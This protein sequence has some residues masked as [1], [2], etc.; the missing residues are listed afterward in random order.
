MQVNDLPKAVIV[1]NPADPAQSPR[2]GPTVI[3][4]PC[5]VAEALG[6]R[7]TRTAGIIGPL[8]NVPPRVP[9]PPATSI[10]S[11]LLAMGNLSSSL[12]TV[13]SGLAIGVEQYQARYMSHRE[14]ASVV[15]LTA[16]ALFT[17]S[18]S[19]LAGAAVLTIPLRNAVNPEV[20][21]TAVPTFHVSL[22]LEESRPELAS[23]PAGNAE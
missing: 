20:E 5:D 14:D 7:A 6:R 21:A 22:S 23:D 8:A 16:N 13:V 4:L 10:A 12:G 11:T 3:G 19:L 18:A 17:M 1:I 9:V 15:W 2:A